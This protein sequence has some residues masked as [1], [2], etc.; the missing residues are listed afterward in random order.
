VGVTVLH[1]ESNR[2]EAAPRRLA[3]PRPGLVVTTAWAI[4]LACSLLPTILLGELGGMEV[5]RGMRTA[6]TVLVLAAAG[7]GTVAV[8]PLRVLR[9]LLAVLLVLAVAQWVVFGVV[10]EL[11][12]VRALLRDPAFGVF[13]PAE[14]VL[15]LAV[16][17]AV[18]AVLLAL[19]RDRHAFYLAR[20]D[21]A[22]P[23]A[24]IRWMGVGPG[25]RWS[26]VGPILAV[27]ISGGTLAFLLLSGTPSAGLLG[28]AVASLPAILFAAAL[29]AFN[30]EVSWKASLLSVLD[31]PVGS[32]DALRMTAAFFGIGHFY[33]VP[34]GIVGV[35]LAWFLGWILARSM[36]DTRGLAWAWCIHFLQDVLIF[37][38]LAAAAI[39]PGGG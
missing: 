25:D 5:T 34:Y 26:T 23:A 39:V 28:A 21:L 36:L 13:L 24:P 9:P 4:V 12:A 32:R 17:L 11:P 16:T 30:E 19:T 22:A 20:G 8:A 1:G 18:I 38:F 31:G 35:A 6:W 37:S 2:V 33:G 27:A 3:M 14:M 10:A 7:L 15:N 29:N